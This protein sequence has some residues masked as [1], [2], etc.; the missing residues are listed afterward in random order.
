MSKSNS[1]IYQPDEYQQ[2]KQA[3]V[4]LFSICFEMSRIPDSPALASINGRSSL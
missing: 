4:Q 1:P 3:A 2:V